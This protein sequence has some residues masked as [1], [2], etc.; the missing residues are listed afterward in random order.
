[1][2]DK[3]KILLVE[4]DKFLSEM[5]VTKLTGSGFDVETAFDGEEALKKAKEFK[6]DLVF[7]DIVLPKKDGFEVLSALKDG[8]FLPDMKVIALTNLGQKE[9]VAKGMSLGASDYIVKAH[10]TPTEVVAKAKKV[11][12]I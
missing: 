11:L 4:D 5:Y 10:F 3:I 2:P 9:E 8:G 1:M 6:P 12:G 7:L